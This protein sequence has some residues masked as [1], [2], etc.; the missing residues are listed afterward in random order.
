MPIAGRERRI[1]PN[2]CQSQGARGEYALLDANRREGEE[3]IP[4][5]MPIAGRLRRIYPS[6]Y[7]GRLHVCRRSVKEEYGRVGGLGG[8]THLP[9]KAPICMCAGGGAY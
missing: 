1:C 2:R 5:S 3:N 9:G 8:Q 6:G 4:Y 7:A